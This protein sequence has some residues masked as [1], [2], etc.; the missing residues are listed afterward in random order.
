MSIYI[1]LLILLALAVTLP[2]VRG[3]VRKQNAMA[4]TTKVIRRNKAPSL[5]AGNKARREAPP[6]KRARRSFKAASVHGRP[7]CC[8]AAKDLEEPR[9]LLDELPDLPL[10][11]CDRLAD[12]KCSF[13]E[14]SD[15]RNNENRR[16]HRR[17]FEKSGVDGDPGTNRRSG[18][19]RRSGLGDELQDIT[20]E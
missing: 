19:D 10:E 15:R 8:Q 16:G 20:F 12:C 6:A 11:A 2:L 18:L 7:G 17:A 13:T 3:F 9:F 1:T 14:H 5:W 4:V